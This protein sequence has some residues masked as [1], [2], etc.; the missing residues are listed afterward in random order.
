MPLLAG[1]TVF[2]SKAGIMLSPT[3]VKLVAWYDNEWGYSSRLCDLVGLMAHRDGAFDNYYVWPEPPLESTIAGESEAAA[4]A[5]APPVAKLNDR[6]S[7]GN[8]SADSV[9]S[10]LEHALALDEAYEPMAGAHGMQDGFG[11]EAVY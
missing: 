1:S 4:H 5:D 8:G 6:M 2:D 10:T 9:L 11:G 3:F 7:V